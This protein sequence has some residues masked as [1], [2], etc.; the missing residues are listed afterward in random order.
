MLASGMLLQAAQS[1]NWVLS[2]FAVL[3][4]C[5]AVSRIVS[6]FCLATHRTDHKL[7]GRVTDRLR[8]SATGSVS[9]NGR[10]MLVY[11]V[12][13]QACV[14]ISGPF[15]TPFMLNQLGFSYFQYVFLIAVAFLARIVAIVRWTTLARNFG[16]ATLL[17]IGAISLVPLS[18]LWIVSTS[19]WWLTLVQAVSGIAWAAYELGFFLLFF[20]TIPAR[21]RTKML[22][23]Y[24][25]GNTLAMFTGASVGAFLLDSLGANMQ[26]YFTLFA[27]SSVG[28]GL[29]L[30][31]LVRA[32]LRPVPVHAIA[33]R[34][35][36]VR[37]ATASLDVPVLSSLEDESQP[38]GDGGQL[39]PT[40]F[41]TAAS[42]SGP[43]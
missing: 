16:A 10:R 19:L 39:Q 43:D 40:R 29:A 37:T 13:V 25:F 15:F 3:F 9:R 33:I 14:Q 1:G 26:A 36:G 23:Y 8:Q 22:T 32:N 5:A 35:L 12:V 34:V 38:S 17:W 6:V 11:L 42:P 28:R 21:R 27:I 31:L 20:E 18:S 41:P 30:V 4:G 2:G 7:A 24:N